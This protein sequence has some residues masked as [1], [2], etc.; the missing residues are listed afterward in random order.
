M[1][2]QIMGDRLLVIVHICWLHENLCTELQ[3]MEKVH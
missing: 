1:L 2:F 3:L